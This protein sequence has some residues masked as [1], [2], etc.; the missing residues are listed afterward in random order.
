MPQRWTG[1]IVVLGILGAVVLVLALN[2]NLKG[3]N[4]LGP[5]PVGEVA[6]A[7]FS[8]F[9]QGRRSH[10]STSAGKKKRIYL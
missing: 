10:N 1:P 5:N 4:A 7:D 8:G 2:L 9:F 6:P 3:W